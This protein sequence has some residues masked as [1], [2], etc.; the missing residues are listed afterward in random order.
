MPL[1]LVGSGWQTAGLPRTPSLLQR[2]WVVDGKQPSG[3][4]KVLYDS[5]SAVQK[6]LG[7]VGLSLLDAATKLTRAPELE[8]GPGLLH[9]QGSLTNLKSGRRAKAHPGE[10]ECNSP[11]CLGLGSAGV[12]LVGAI[13]SQGF[14]GIC[15]CGLVFVFVF[16]TFRCCFASRHLGE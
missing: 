8:A 7:E 6:L 16:S 13:L 10:V 4:T 12:G 15:T 2:C 14:G 3:K 5:D 11:P 1:P 9:W